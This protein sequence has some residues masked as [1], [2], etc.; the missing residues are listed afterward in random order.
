[1]EITSVHG[2]SEYVGAPGAVRGA[3]AGHTVIDA[4]NRGYRLAFIGSGDGHV[5]HPG[6]RLSP[7]PW[8]MAGLWVDE[9]TREGVFEAL[10]RRSV[11]ATTGP[12]IVVRFS[13]GGVPMG[14]VAEIG[15]E[16]DDTLSVPLPV[17]GEVLGTEP[18]ELIE[19]VKNGEAIV[20]TTPVEERLVPR[21]SF[22]IDAV[23]GDYLY[24]RATQEGGAMA[25]SSPVWV[26]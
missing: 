20:R 5:G 3:R 7:F 12:R 2:V 14:S 11:F 24:L 8:G 15:S 22:E 16:A 1:M 9:L 18:V 19:I 13:V 17:L 26:E 25:W 21:F 10:K 4:L 23:R 6:R